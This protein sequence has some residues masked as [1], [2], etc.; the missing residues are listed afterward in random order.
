M[1]N[2]EIFFFF[3]NFMAFLFGMSSTSM[4]NTVINYISENSSELIF[5]WS[6]TPRYMLIIQIIIIEWDILKDKN[7]LLVYQT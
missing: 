7:I 2:L 4:Q 6:D 1:M 3:I 5:G